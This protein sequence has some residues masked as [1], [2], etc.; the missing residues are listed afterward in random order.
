MKVIGISI[1]GEEKILKPVLATDTYGFLL[2]KAKKLSVFEKHKEV[3][4]V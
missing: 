3:F 4:K 2:I 1:C